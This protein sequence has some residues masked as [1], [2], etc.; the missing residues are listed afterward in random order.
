MQRLVSIKKPE[1]MNAIIEKGKKFNSMVDE[2]HS[3]T[4]SNPLVAVKFI[5][6]HIEYGLNYERAGAYGNERTLCLRSKRRK[7]NFR[8]FFYVGEK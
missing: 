4:I 1:G 5:C 3:I 8:T 2:T 7:N 6:M